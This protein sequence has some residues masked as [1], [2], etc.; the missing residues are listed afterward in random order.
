MQIH[1]KANASDVE[2]KHDSEGR[3]VFWNQ[4]AV[5]DQSAKRGEKSVVE[6]SV[7]GLAYSLK[8]NNNASHNNKKQKK[9]KNKRIW[10]VKNATAVAPVAQSP[11]VIQDRQKGKRSWYTKRA[12]AGTKLADELRRSIAEAKGAKDALHQQKRDQARRSSVE[13]KPA[14]KS[15]FSIYNEKKAVLE[16]L[17]EEFPNHVVDVKENLKKVLSKR[18]YEVKDKEPI[19]LYDMFERTAG[20]KMP[21]F[22]MWLDKY[23]LYSKNM[24]ELA[25]RMRFVLTKKNLDEANYSNIKSQGENW[26]R[27]YGLSKIPLCLVLFDDILDDL[28]ADMTLQ[29]HAGLIHKLR[30]KLELLEEWRATYGM[31]KVIKRT[32][33]FFFSRYHLD[34]S[35]PINRALGAWARLELR[36]KYD[37]LKQVYTWSD[38]FKT[39]KQPDDKELAPHVECQVTLNKYIVDYCVGSYNKIDELL[40]DVPYLD[41]M[42]N[43]T[44]KEAD[45]EKCVPQR[46]LIGFS[47]NVDTLWIPRLCTHNEKC[48]CLTRQMMPA[49]YE[50]EDYDALKARSK[51]MWDEAAKLLLKE[52]DWPELMLEEPEVMFAHFI[53][54]YPIRRREQ[55]IRAWN[56]IWAKG[57]DEDESLAMV[58]AFVKREVLVGKTRRKRQPRLISGKLDEYLAVTCM[59]YFLWQKQCVAKLWTATDLHDPVFEQD[60]IYSGGMDG[61]RIGQIISHYEAKGYW[62]YEGDYSRYDGHTED[63]ALEAEYS[64]IE[65]KCGKVTA[66]LFRRSIKRSGYTMGGHKY[67]LMGKMDS[68]MIS[69]SFGN[70]KR[71]FMLALMM[72]KRLKDLGFLGDKDRFVVM[73]L[74]DDNLFFVSKRIPVDVL[75]DVA[76]DMGHVLETKEHSPADYDFIEYCS[77][78]P[79]RVSPGKRVL[80][81]KIGRVLTKSFVMSQNLP[82]DM[83]IE[84]WM[85]VVAVGFKNYT[86]LPGLG[87]VIDCF[88][89]TASQHPTPE[90]QVTLRNPLDEIDYTEVYSMF[91]N[92]YG[93]DPLDLITLC[94]S[95]DWT[96][97]GAC[98]SHE[99]FNRIC[100]TDGCLTHNEPANLVSFERAALV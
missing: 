79:W 47:V 85:R 97:V 72:K 52:I 64:I 25:D 86:W 12:N 49:L 48:A 66:D 60:Y 9:N 96:L 93:F 59:P 90:W 7:V 94:M 24:F 65:A 88:D 39:F 43:G 2:I 69:T 95:V 76:R 71:G 36:D 83:T 5:P 61:E 56:N 75:I 6:M 77:M 11:E 29:Y 91:G 21:K 30:T 28:T 22:K 63:E 100:D 70:T 54:R 26:V 4:P 87:Q 1:R 40:D 89:T 67:K 27:Q 84:Q 98:Y 99:L 10:K 31:S 46:T 19:Y 81:P 78:R 45:R 35:K 32:D 58:K 17:V 92:V 3:P 20:K 42:R 18:D 57:L 55:L 53:S 68:G 74:G 62:C 80:G 14:E 8:D 33:D 16:F 23:P 37:Y 50:G 41:K 51:R 13:G 82:T 38:C 73:Q 44:F 15:D 34:G